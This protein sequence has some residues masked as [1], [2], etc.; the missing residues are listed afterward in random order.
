MTK[1]VQEIFQRDRPSDN[2]IHILVQLLPP[3][4]AGKQPLEDSDECQISKRAKL[5]D[6]NIISTA[7]TFKEKIMKLS[8]ELEYYSNPKN[9]FPL[10]FLYLGRKKPI[11]R[12][13]IDNNGYFN[14][15]GRKEFRN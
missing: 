11:E 8:D 14:F 7:H 2:N 1:K 15:M 6:P 3:T 12:F 9:L 10:P 13:T 5:A 4:T